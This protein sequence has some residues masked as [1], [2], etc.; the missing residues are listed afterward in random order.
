M[1]LENDLHHYILGVDVGRSVSPKSPKRQFYQKARDRLR[2]G[3]GGPSGD[4]TQIA[5]NSHL[6]E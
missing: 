6:G 2:E 3:A 5:E 4:G 1:S